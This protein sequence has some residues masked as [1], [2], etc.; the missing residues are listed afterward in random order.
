MTHCEPSLF[1]R[2]RK[3]L[4]AINLNQFAIERNFFMKYSAARREEHVNIVSI[5][6]ITAHFLLRR[7]RSRCYYWKKF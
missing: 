6:E 4:K 2:L 5:T 3:L 7:S 1:G